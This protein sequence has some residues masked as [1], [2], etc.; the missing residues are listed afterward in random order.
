MPGVA[1]QLQVALGQMAIYGSSY[2]LT[3]LETLRLEPYRGRK[4]TRALLREVAA[5]IGISESEATGSLRLLRECGFLAHEDKTAA[6]PVA[7]VV[8]YTGG[9]PNASIRSYHQHLLSRYQASIDERPVDE[10]IN[11]AIQMPIARAQLEEIRREVQAFHAQLIQ[12]YAQA[13]GGDD[14]LLLSAAGTLSLS[15]K[16][17]NAK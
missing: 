3:L 4:L 11:D 8:L 7:G 17:E 10:R 13:E 14:V 5:R 2:T 12:K 1:P 6:D 16:Q 15:K 9:V